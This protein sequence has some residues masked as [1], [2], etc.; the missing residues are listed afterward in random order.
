MLV[1]LMS[2]HNIKK[3]NIMQ[4]EFT[5]TEVKQLIGLLDLAT[6]S[7]GLQVAQD[8]LPLALKLQKSLDESESD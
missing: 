8:A 5:K 2:E 1:L 6:K 4:I 7:G 3:E